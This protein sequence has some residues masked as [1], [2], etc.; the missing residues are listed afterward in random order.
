MPVYHFCTQTYYR[1]NFKL[2]RDLQLK[3]NISP[4]LTPKVTKP[5]DSKQPLYLITDLQTTPKK[6]AALPAHQE[7]RNAEVYD[8]NRLKCKARCNLKKCMEVWAWAVRST[9]SVNQREW[10]EEQAWAR[11]IVM[12]LWLTQLHT[13][14]LQT[15]T[16]HILPGWGGGWGAV[17]IT[18]P[19][20]NKSE[21]PNTAVRCH[22]SFDVA[23]LL[24][25]RT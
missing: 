20:F 16:A 1:L 14:A 10:K 17:T 23:K 13:A 3:H 22:P 4:P 25:L 6:G 11:S 5:S 15:H 24:L 21:G 12:V 9:V 8:K 18:A 19:V 2:H 7:L